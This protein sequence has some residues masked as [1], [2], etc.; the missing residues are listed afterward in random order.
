[1]Q[2]WVPTGLWLTPQTCQV[3]GSPCSA[4]TRLTRRVL[5]FCARSERKKICL[6]TK[7]IMLR[8]FRSSG[9]SYVFAA[10]DRP[11]VIYSSNKK[12]LYSNVNENEVG[13]LALML[14]HSYNAGC[15]VWTQEIRFAAQL[16]L[17]KEPKH[18]CT[19]IGY[20]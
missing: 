5:R 3:L 1:M 14:L 6:G 12:L 17:F 4:C 13:A 10:S 15:C 20:P 18:T 11:T 7:P 19:T 2:R 9:T 8:T 16:Q